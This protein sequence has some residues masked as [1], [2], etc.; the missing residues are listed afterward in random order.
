MGK[1]WPLLIFLPPLLS[2]IGCGQLNG[3]IKIRVQSESLLNPDS[4]NK[5]LPV[6][7]KVFQLK[8]EQTFHQARFEDIWKKPKEALSPSLLSSQEYV[9]YP[10][11]VERYSFLKTEHARFLGIAATFRKPESEDWRQI[12]EIPVGIIPKSVRIHLKNNQVNLMK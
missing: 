10:D 4:E 12:T 9:I 2:G 5:S 3:P 11:T 1:K 8:D 7:L 6:V